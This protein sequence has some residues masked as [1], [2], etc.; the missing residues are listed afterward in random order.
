MKEQIRSLAQQHA[1]DLS[2][3]Q[4]SLRSVSANRI[5][6]KALLSDGAEVAR[7]WFD[8]VKPA[9]ERARFDANT[10]TAFSSRFDELLLATQGR[11]SKSKLLSVVGEILPAYRVDIGHQIETGS[12]SADTHL[13][14][15]PYIEGLPDDEGRF[16]DEAQRC[17]AVNALRGCI[18]LGWC[19]TISRIHNKI[20][21]IGFP[22]FNRAT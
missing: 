5:S 7:K 3:F 17:L 6:Q 14:I 2:A 1:A 10:I 20:E 16:L 22:A 15:A 13:S 19:A 12:F 11:P 4:R 9:L 21:A 18:V 8:V